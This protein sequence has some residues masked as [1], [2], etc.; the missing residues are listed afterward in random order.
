MSGGPVDL[1]ALNRLFGAAMSLVRYT[2]EA[3]GKRF[4][5]S[6]PPADKAGAHHTL[7]CGD[8]QNLEL[9]PEGDALSRPMRLELADLREDGLDRVHFSLEEVE[10]DTLFLH[11]ADVAYDEHGR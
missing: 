7:Q 4:N 11:C 1:D 9:L 8:G 2:L 3:D 10:R 6:L 5:L